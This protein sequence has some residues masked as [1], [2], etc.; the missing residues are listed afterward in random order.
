MNEHG[1]QHIT[2]EIAVVVPKRIVKEED[3]SCDCVDVLVDE[4]RKEGLIIDRVLG[5]AD[6][7]F[8]K[9]LPFYAE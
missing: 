5:L 6:H 9:V 2:Y 8:I 4:F 7:E 3:N 1:D